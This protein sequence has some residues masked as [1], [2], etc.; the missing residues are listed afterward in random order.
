M[1][2]LSDAG[3]ARDRGLPEVVLGQGDLQAARR[4][5]Q[6]NVSAAGAP[7][8]LSICASCH[9]VGGQ[10]IAGKIPAL[11]RQWRREGAGPQDVI[12][13]VLG[14]L[15]AGHGLSPMPAVGSGM[16]R[17]GDRR[18]GQL[19]AHGLGQRRARQ[20]G[21]GL[22]AKLRA[23][24]ARPFGRLGRPLP[25]ARNADPAL[26]KAVED[27]GLRESLANVPIG[28]MLQPIDAI[29]SKVKAKAPAAKDDDIVNALTQAYCP[30]AMADTH[31]A[32]PDRTA[33]LGAFSVLVYGQL[34][35]GGGGPVK[36]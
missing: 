12:R 4:G 34:K 2:Y 21:A 26:S 29:L 27:S 31:V 18:H 35:R 3:P 36:N 17:P 8:Y 20:R 23:E 24:T 9:G 6:Q 13:V 11:G 32:G 10:G 15:V 33:R 5:Q 14:G 22:V 1:Q 30:L 16:T 19:R 28:N 25:G 7:T